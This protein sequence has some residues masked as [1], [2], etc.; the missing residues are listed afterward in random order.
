[1]KINKFIFSVLAVALPFATIAQTKKE[2]VDA[3]NSG[4]TMIKEN[5]QG[6]L[7]KLYEAITISEQLGEEGEETKVLAESLIPGVHF[8]FAMN[9]YKQKKS[10]ETIEQL[11]KAEETAVKFGDAKTQQKVEKTIPKLYYA[12]GVNH[13]KAD[14]FEKA[15]EY[16]N[17]AIQFNGG[18]SDPIL[19]LALSYEKMEDYEKMLEYLAKTI[20]VAKKTNDNGKAEDALKKA[21]GYLMR[22]GDEAQK[23]EKFDDAVKYFSRVLE[24]DENDGSIYYVLAI[25]YN[26]L[27]NWDKAIE[28][29]NIAVEKGNGTID[30]AGVYYQLG[31]AYQGKGSNAEACESFSKA[32]S[33]S[34]KAAAEYQMKEVLKCN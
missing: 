4:A 34:Y 33:G 21:K 17:K 9:L 14:E 8:E 1:M 15:I 16:Y 20:E 11:E 22:N 10:V 26:S 18:F 29:A 2:A 5:P 25:N 32:L 27:K 24:F 6:A 13:Y 3:Y 19:G 28:N 7:D 12:M 23:A 31:V 30:S